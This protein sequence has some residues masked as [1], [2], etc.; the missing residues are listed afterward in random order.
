MP[1]AEK[2]VRGKG[3]QPL[4]PPQHTEAPERDERSGREPIRASPIAKQRAPLAKY[5]KLAEEHGQ[6]GGQP[7][8][9]QRSLAGAPRKTL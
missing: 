1:L 9:S 6:S 4:S 8:D 7:R 3:R 2:G 5:V